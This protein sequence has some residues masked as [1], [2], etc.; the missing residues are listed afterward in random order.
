MKEI[1]VKKKARVLNLF[2]DKC[3][4][5]RPSQYRSFSGMRQ[6]SGKRTLKLMFGYDKNK[7]PVYSEPIELSTL[8]MFLESQRV[9]DLHLDKDKI[10]EDL[11]SGLEEED[12]Y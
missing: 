4:D 6:A 9:L 12:E 10:K 2:K 11:F 1:D 3:G 8:A 5:F 7:N